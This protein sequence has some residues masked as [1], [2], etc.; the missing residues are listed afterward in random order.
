MATFR[1]K[2]RRENGPIRQIQ[3]VQKNLDHI[4]V[5]LVTGRQL[6]LEE[7][8]KVR[9]FMLSRLGCPSKL[10]F[11]YHDEIPRSASGKYEDFLSEVGT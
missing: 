7:E 4:E 2:T 3:C 10:T 8:E 6:T 9:E 11:T 5:R 1:G